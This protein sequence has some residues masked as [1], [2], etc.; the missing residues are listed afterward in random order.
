LPQQAFPDQV[1]ALATSNIEL[2]L[3]AGVSG[4]EFVAE[5]NLFNNPIKVTVK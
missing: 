4:N 1:R 2:I 5:P 3:Q